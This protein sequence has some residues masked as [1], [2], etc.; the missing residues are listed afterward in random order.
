VISTRPAA[1]EFACIVVVAACGLPACGGSAE[2]GGPGGPAKESTPGQA[3]ETIAFRLEEENRSGGSGRATLKGD[4]RAISVVLEVRPADERYHAHIH[5]VSCSDY[6]GM[7]S[8]GAQLATVVQGLGD[9]VDGRSE[10]NVNAAL[11]SYR[12]PGFSIN[13]HEYAHPYPVIACGDL[14]SS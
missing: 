10:T 12:K 13:V 9:L 4:D 5:N 8:T 1:G 11:T 6:R 7:T 14:P 3:A 2:V